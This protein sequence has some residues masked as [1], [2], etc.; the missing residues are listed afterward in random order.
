MKDCSYDRIV[1]GVR[2]PK[3]TDKLIQ[4]GSELKLQNAMKIAWIYE[5]SQ[6]RSMA[7]E[8]NSV[9]Y[10]QRTKHGQQHKS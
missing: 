4:V 1:N 6:A 3:I 2:N 9:H 10:I 5:R 7:G 8:D